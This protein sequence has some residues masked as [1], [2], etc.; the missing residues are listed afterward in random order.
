MNFALYPV[1][2]S[3][4]KNSLKFWGCDLYNSATYNPEN[5]VHVYVLTLIDVS[6]LCVMYF[7]FFHIILLLVEGRPHDGLPLRRPVTVSV[8]LTVI[9]AFLATGGIIFAIVCL[10]FNTVFRDRK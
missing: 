8:A 4:L 1:I 5:T 9:F 7:T 2:F 6:C 10:V 3:F